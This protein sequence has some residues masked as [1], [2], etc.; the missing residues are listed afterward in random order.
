MY[1]DLQAGNPVEADP[2]LGDLRERARALGVA[3]PLVSAA[4]VQLS[5]H[6]RQRDAA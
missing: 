5:I 2:V 4:F 3:T 6:Q 1:R